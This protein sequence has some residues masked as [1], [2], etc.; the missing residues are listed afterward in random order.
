MIYDFETLVSRKNTG[1]GKWDEMTKEHP[2]LPENV[3]PLS[4]A[5]MELKNP[6]EIVE[7]LKKY[8]DTHILGYTGPTEEYFN[9]VCGWMKRR[10]DWDIK[11]E[12]IV[13][14]HG[15]V[16]ALAVS[17]LAYTDPGDG[18]ITMP[19]VYYPFRMTIEHNNRK[20]VEC[21]LINTNET[22]TIDF[23]LFEK[24]CA[25]EKN[26]M[27]IFCNPHN[28]V[29]RVWTENEIAKLG[30]IC[31]KH[32]VIVV[33]DEIH[34]DLIMPGHKHVAFANACKDALPKYLV[35][36]APS[37]TFNLATL[38]TSNIII[39]D[40]TLRKKFQAVLDMVDANAATALGMEACRLGYTRCEGWL[41]EAI[42]LIWHNFQFCSRFIA[43]NCPGVTCSRLE[44]T[45]LM[46][47][48]CESLG[49]DDDALHQLLFKHD[50]YCNDGRF[51][52]AGGERH[53]RINLAGPA[54]MLEAA[55][56]R[57]KAACAEVLPQ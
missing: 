22:Y 52:S 8:I 5:D 50:L 1:S 27:F 47:I 24:L 14:T 39:P 55:M 18:V 10:N 30:A 9:A 32:N 56:Q 2:N 21:P 37:K 33:S 38:Q 13:S 36:T 54:K 11:K 16:T 6:P 25:E 40:E 19:P 48:N 34:S 29:G 7:G 53:I 20:N 49:L 41:D 31:A 4:V 35:C 28:P 51:F 45:Y 57:F 3:A 44:G 17:V 43:E 12:E 15:V 23:D 26:K 46:W 42:D